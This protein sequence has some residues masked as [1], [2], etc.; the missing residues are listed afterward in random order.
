MEL[1]ASLKGAASKS[2]SEKEIAYLLKETYGNRRAEIKNY[3]GRPM[4]KL[5]EDFPVLKKS[6]FVSISIYI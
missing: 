2:N 1:K 3:A 6:E 4:Y 5:C